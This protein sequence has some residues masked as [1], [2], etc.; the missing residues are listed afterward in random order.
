MKIRIIVS[1]YDIEGEINNP[2]MIPLNDFNSDLH[3]FFVHNGGK[4]KTLEILEYM[5]V[6]CRDYVSVLELKKHQTAA[7]AKKVGERYLSA[8]A[9]LVS[10]QSIEIDFT[11]NHQKRINTIDKGIE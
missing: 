11:T 1:C 8:R 9:D 10:V 4:D 2:D 5:R 3:F 6:E 7:A